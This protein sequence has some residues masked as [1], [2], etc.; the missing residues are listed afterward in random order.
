MSHPSLFQTSVVVATDIVT[1]TPEQLLPGAP[2]VVD[3]P[4]TEL[5]ALTEPVEYAVGT[6]E[7][8]PTAKV[9]WRRSE[10]RERCQEDTLGP[11]G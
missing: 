3:R 9:I 1:R 5:P 8:I 4:L 10:E 11:D 2:L 6:T 7:I